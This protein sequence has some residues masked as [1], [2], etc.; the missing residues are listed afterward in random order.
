MTRTTI[1]TALAT[2]VAVPVLYAQTFTFGGYVK[3]DVIATK[4]H[5]GAPSP[6]GPIRDFHFPAQVPVGGA[7]DIF[8][9]M[10]FHAKE[11]RL[12][13][14]VTKTLDNGKTLKAFAE[15]DFLLSGQGD[16]R[17]SNSFNPRLRH[18]YFS[19][20]KW[21]LGQTWSTFQVVIMP[22]DIDFP[23]A[24]DGIVFNRQ[25]QVRFT[26]GPWQFSVENPET[27]L[28]PYQ[29]G[30]RITT[31]AATMP[32]IV[33]RR[34]FN[35]DRGTFSVAGILRRLNHQFE[36][37]GRSEQ[38]AT[39][40]W[41]VTLGAQIK[42]GK[43]DDLRFQAAAGDGLGRYVAFGLSNGAVVTDTRQVEGIPSYLGYVGYRH[44]W[45]RGLR[46]NVNVSGIRVDNDVALTGFEVSRE[47]YSASANLI[48]S[49]IP[50]LS[51]GLEYMSAWRKLESGATG[52]FDR[53]QFAGKYDFS[54]S[55]E[56]R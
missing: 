1:V 51:F 24:A 3:L 32:D 56:K 44:F 46:T 26:T 16:E 37:D 48:Y 53:L 11:S 28:E 43:R 2:L 19:Y 42:V 47:A 6:E 14:D 49:P 13:F 5:D 45:A 22:E 34:N 36:V 17:I 7:S 38:N 33:G 52:R 40:G 29:G 18:F 9:E 27:T 55:I 8:G 21:L 50:E 15:M 35:G 30:P 12:H 25:P 10:S 41:G 54:F 31:E 4:Y 23:G 39:V 20:G